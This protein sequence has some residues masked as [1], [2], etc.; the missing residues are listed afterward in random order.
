VAAVIHVALLRGINV[1]GNN[2]LPMADL[3]RIFADLGMPGATTYINTGNVVFAGPPTDR[4]ALATTVEQAVE[5]EFGFRPRVLVCSG[6][7][8][9]AI[10]EAI[11]EDWTN[12]PAMKSDV[13]YLIDGVDPADAVAEL[14]PRDGIDH[15]VLAPGALIWMVARA[16]AGRSGLQRLI[17]TELYRR[18]TVRN[19]NTARRLAELVAQQQE[20]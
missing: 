7:D 20:G 11:P 2:T 13:V 14:A 4:V 10:A 12:G 19:V 6:D 8:V 1:G 5:A 16:D 15:V 3:R 9:R 18:S 17:G